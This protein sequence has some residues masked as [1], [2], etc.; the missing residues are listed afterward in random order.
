VAGRVAEDGNR[1][2]ADLMGGGKGWE[3]RSTMKRV[4]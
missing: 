3:I 1:G 2:S 4:R